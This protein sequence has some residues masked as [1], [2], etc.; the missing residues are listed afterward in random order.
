[1]FAAMVQLAGA[2]SS[3]CCSIGRGSSRGRLRSLRGRQTD[4]ARLSWSTS[5]RGDPERAARGNG[6][7]INDVRADFAGEGEELRVR[8][9]Y[10][11]ANR[12]F[13]GP[14]GRRARRSTKGLSGH[15]EKAKGESPLSFPFLIYSAP[16]GL[17][18]DPDR[19][20]E[21]LN[22]GQIS[23]RS[24][25]FQE[26][27]ERDEFVTKQAC[28]GYCRRGSDGDD[29]GGRVDVGGRRRRHCRAAR[30][31]GVGRLARGRFSTPAPSRFSISA[32]SPIASSRRAKQCR[33]RGSP[34]SRWTS[35][36]FRHGT[37]TGSPFGR[38]TLN[39]SWPAGSKS[40]PSRS[41]A[42][43]R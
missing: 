33:S 15:S 40:W 41:I 37:T 32:G 5:Y 16:G 9:L 36:I 11:L 39:A 7:A 23:G 21:S 20:V 28:G 26:W 35:A 8:R 29:A 25:N 22:L 6:D 24:Q 13:Q 3:V 14:R 2:C 10:L 17:R 34:T 42:D 12:V 30:E 18:Q 43:A 27:E 1:V 38:S 4:S 31:R 19:T